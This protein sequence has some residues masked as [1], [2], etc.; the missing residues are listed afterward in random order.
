[1]PHNNININNNNNNNITSY[2]REANFVLFAWSSVL[3]IR[4]YSFKWRSYVTSILHIVLFCQCFI[5]VLIALMML[6]YSTSIRLCTVPPLTE[7][8]IHENCNEICKVIRNSYIRIHL[9]LHILYMCRF[10]ATYTQTKWQRVFQ[11][12]AEH[13]DCDY[14]RYNGIITRYSPYV[15]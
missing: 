6:I 5:S 13:A 7:N 9:R 3:S 14:G 2:G 1:M 12:S 15:I 8:H 10:T 11:A 4:L